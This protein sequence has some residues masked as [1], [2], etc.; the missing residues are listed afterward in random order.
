M[1]KKK[2]F[3][4]YR[5]QYIQILSTFF[6]FAHKNM[7]SSRCQYHYI[8]NSN[9]KLFFF[10]LH[11]KNTFSSRFSY[12]H[13]RRVKKSFLCTKKKVLEISILV[14][15]NSIFF[16][17]KNFFLD[18]SILAYPNTNFFFHKRK[19]FLRDI[20]ISISIQ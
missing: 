5:H 15:P 14:Y 9:K 18:I 11:E 12:D 20:H 10:F 13:N 19:T 2:T 17:K 8:K 6:S 7:F 3:S 16:Y 1:P 4:R